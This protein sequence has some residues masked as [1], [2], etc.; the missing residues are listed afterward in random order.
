[1]TISIITVVLNARLTIENTIESVLGQTYGNIEYIIIDGGST[2]GTLD[3]VNKYKDKI[4]KIVSE[5]DKGIYDGMNKGVKLASGDII[6][7]LNA[8]D[9]YDNRFVLETVVRAIAENNSD[10]CYGDLVYV[11]RYDTD[12]I[13]RCWKSCEYKEGLLKKGWIPP[14]PTFFVKRSAYK[15]FGMFDINFPLAADYDLMFRFLERHK[16]KSCYIPQV[17]VKMRA[18]GSSNKGLSNLIRQNLEIAR[19]L[20]QNGINNYFKFFLFKIINKLRQFQLW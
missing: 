12:K 10:A 14:H 19:I 5:P 16:I 11:D 8:D 4:S 6:G 13:K 7:I 17:L 3:I 18:G 1:M 9:I 2:D 15:D 20:K